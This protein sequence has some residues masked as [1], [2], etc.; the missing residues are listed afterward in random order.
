VNDT[1][2]H[3]MARFLVRP[4]VGTGVRP[5]HIT[6]LRLL[7][8]MFACGLLALGTRSGDIWGGVW[9][10]VSAFL[11]RAD[12]E[13]ARIGDMQSRA[14]HLYDFYCDVLINSLF[15]L[16]VGIGQRHSFLGPWSILLGVITFA[17]MILVC[18][19]AEVYEKISGP[20]TAASGFTSM[21]P[22]I[23]WGRSRGSD[24]WRPSWRRR[25]LARAS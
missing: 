10:V 3:A 4:L 15:F 18:W 1:W 13:L 17:A 12:G 16:G 6:T 8:G 5:N 9:W 22:S 14:G 19:L 25:A 23:F 21:T 20:S 24:G 11:D 7:T 2:T